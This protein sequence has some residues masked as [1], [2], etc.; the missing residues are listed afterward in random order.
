MNLGLDI[1]VEKYGGLIFDSLTNYSFKIFL[2][3]LILVIGFKVIKYLLKIINKIFASQRVAPAVRGFL[4]SLI[5]AVLKILVLIMVATILGFPMT[6]FV[7]ILGAAGLAVG[8]SLQGSLA[9]FA[10]GVLILLFKPFKLGDY[11][12]TSSYSGT[13]EEITIFSTVLVTIDNK[14]V[15]IPNGNLSNSEVTNY[16]AKK[17]R[18]LDLVF[19]VGYDDDIKKVR[20][21]LMKIV[22]ADKRILKD[23][24][25]F[26]AMGELADNSVNF[27]VRPWC[28]TDEYW[29]IKY[30]LLEKVKL[31]FDK[32]K[33]SIPYPQMDIHMK[34]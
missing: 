11:I 1:D 21:I 34:K 2:S 10:G 25:P 12:S 17:T 32:E 9:N 29:S 20:E 27:Y 22:K 19:G 28:K 24:A 16:T 6:S 18:R 8:L 5:S 13:V 30:D 14:V 26:V 33:I 3:I 15:I 4:D 31:A 7:A 23:P